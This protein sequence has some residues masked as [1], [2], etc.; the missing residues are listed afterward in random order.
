[1]GYPV[2]LQKVERPT[3]RSYYINLPAAVAEAISVNKGETFEWSI[4]DKNTL[5]LSR[6]HKQTFRTFRKGR[7]R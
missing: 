5:V 1:V 7:S 4:E 3:N 2:K 6:T